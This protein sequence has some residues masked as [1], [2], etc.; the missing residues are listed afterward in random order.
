MIVWAIGR[1]AAVCMD[2]ELFIPERFLEK[3][4]VYNCQ[5]FEL[6]PF[7]TGRRICPGLPLAFQ[8]V[9]LILASLLLPFKW[10]LPNGM[11]PV[12]VNMDENFGM[13]LAKAI[14]LCTIPILDA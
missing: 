2:P 5:D 6:I 10:K 9:H 14:P 3:D 8:M 12:D 11:E 7:G 1:D 4:V 13:S